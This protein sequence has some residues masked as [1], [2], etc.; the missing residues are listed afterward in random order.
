MA[1]ERDE[2]PRAGGL[3]K[4]RYC[5]DCA[6]WRGETPCPVCGADLLLDDEDEDAATAAPPGGVAQGPTRGEFTLRLGREVLRAAP[7]ALVCATLVG[8]VLAAQTLLP[9]GDLDWPPKIVA[10]FIACAWLLERARS[11][12][13]QGSDLDMVALGGVLLRALYLLPALVGILTLHWAAI[14]VAAVF[15]LLGPLLLAA[16]AGEEPLSDL[17]PRTLLQAFLA[18]DGYAR[19]ATLTAAGLAAMLVP[20]GWDDGDPLWRAPLIGLGA[21]LAGTAAGLARRSAE[22]TP[23]A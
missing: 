9:F 16:L 22:R 18:T 1:R 7:G 4:A 10:G 21:A 19:Y 3:A 6:S 12:R 13:T 14:P 5:A 8:G 23:E 20:L 15:A 2:E 17:G 11:A